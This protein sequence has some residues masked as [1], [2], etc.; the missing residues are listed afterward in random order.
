[1]TKFC[2]LDV[3]ELL[4]TLDENGDFYIFTCGCGEPGCLGDSPIRVSKNEAY[5]FWK[6]QSRSDN[7][8]RIT[9]KFRFHL[10]QYRKEIERLRMSFNGK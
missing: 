9:E 2:G 4:R 7:Q 3:V 1:M 5:L 10:P 6:V 8:I